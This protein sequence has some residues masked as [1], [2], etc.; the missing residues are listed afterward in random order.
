MTLDNFKDAAAA[1]ADIVSAV[2]IILGGIWAYWKFAVQ[3]EREPRAEFDLSA[4]FV[5]KQDGKW[6]IEVSAR[7]ANK[8]KVRHPM[9]EATLNVRYLLSLDTV[10]ESQD[11]THFRQLSFP[12]SIGRRKIWTDSYIDPGL[13]FRN[14][15]VTWV[16]EEATYVLLLCKFRYDDEEWPAQRLLKV[17][18]SA[19]LQ[20]PIEKLPTTGRVGGA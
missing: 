6:L 12:H 17:P 20:L 1:I 8:G 7:L 3:R 16:P 5:G 18:D 11:V 10:G 13:E 19:A 9:T 15:Y 4:E 14:S 2:A